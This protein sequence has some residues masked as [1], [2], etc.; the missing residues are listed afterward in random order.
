MKQNV[1]NS[2]PI[3]AH[4]VARRC[5]VRVQCGGSQ[6]FTDGNIVVLPEHETVPRPV[7]LGYLVH[8][9]AHVRY[10]DFSV[11]HDNA[12]SRWLTNVYEDARVERKISTDYVGANRLLLATMSFLAKEPTPEPQSILEATLTFVAL[13]CWSRYRLMK[14]VLHADRDKALQCLEGFLKKEQS[15]KA[16]D[17]IEALMAIND[18]LPLAKNT[19]DVR[20]LALEV[21]E[22][23][24][25]RFKGLKG[26]QDL[27]ASQAS[28]STK[29]STPPSSSEKQTEPTD[30]HGTMGNTVRDGSLSG[31]DASSA[32][33]ASKAKKGG[34]PKHARET[35][36]DAVTT[37]ALGG[38]AEAS[39]TAVT[40]PS[41]ND[42]NP[43]ASPL[44]ASSGL[45]S[46]YDISEQMK[47]MLDAFEAN[48][49]TKP[50]NSSLKGK[51]GFANVFPNAPLGLRLARGTA[52]THS[53]RIMLDEGRRHSVGLRRQLQ[54][55]VQARGRTQKRLSNGGRSLNRAK[56]GRLATWN[57][58]VFDRIREHPNTA[59]AV[60][61]L[62][63][64]S[65][66]MRGVRETVA[67]ESA[68][69]LFLALESLPDCNP[70]LS[71]FRGRG[72]TVGI[73]RHGERLNES[74]KPRLS[75]IAASGGTP[76][77]PALADV[78]VELSMTKE[79]RK[80]IFVITDGD[81]DNPMET[82]RLVQAIEA[83]SDVEIVGVVIAS[84][85]TWLFEKSV[86]LDD[87][88]TLSDVLFG[89]AKDMALTAIR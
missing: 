3:I 2:L 57:P 5:G 55:L 8:E 68:I 70:A 19:Q 76:L 56:L 66:S 75:E 40:S 24:K 17:F 61:I 82:H 6:A 32:S 58:R 18:R 49:K 52:L 12:L 31:Q 63:D 29:G 43:G 20:A 4:A 54:G 59:T 44:E 62:L 23:L 83:S 81:P 26:F 60:H 79:K 13:D 84:D 80:V 51:S 33:S 67:G 38:V 14:S 47:A 77:L 22:V 7:L 74:T 72:K 78:L 27:N 11:T 42:S 64:M 1:F 30:N 37:D 35:L 85:T 65:G 71:I 53:S 34:S 69:A 39:D 28:S 48:T 86:R 41:N 89:L 36:T 46:F 21:I 15:M 88:S 73:F 25:R 50:Q 16:G 87:V 9:C 45:P 10:T